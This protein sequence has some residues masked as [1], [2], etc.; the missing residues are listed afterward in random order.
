MVL[1]CTQ[2]LGSLTTSCQGG[3]PDLAWRMLP[4]KASRSTRIHWP[5]LSA[6]PLPRRAA[7]ATPRSRAGAIAAVVRVLL[8]GTLILNPEGN[9]SRK[10]RV[11]I[12]NAQ[13]R[14]NRPGGPPPSIGRFPESLRCPPR[15]QAPVP[16][17]SLAGA[18]TPSNQRGTCA[19]DRCPRRRARRSRR[20][21]G[22]DV[23]QRIHAPPVLLLRRHRCS[24][25]NQG[26]WFDE[27]M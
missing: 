3:H 13:L 5:L 24:I 23:G 21:A 26:H 22:G 12:S 9:R 18:A 1:Q 10:E 17:P 15:S 20:P 8:L 25:G 19:R 6:V 11:I 14:P 7:G 27:L 4:R 2:D 16:L